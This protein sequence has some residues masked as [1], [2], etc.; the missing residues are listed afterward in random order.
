LEEL[1]ELGLRRALQQMRAFSRAIR[2]CPDDVRAVRTAADLDRLGDRIGLLLALEGCEPFGYEV[3]LADTFFE[4]GVRMASLTWNRRNP[5]ADGAAETGDGGLSSLGRRLVTR[6]AEL[7]V[8]IDLAHASERTFF[9]VL[10]QAPEATVLVS[11]G[12]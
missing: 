12:N 5:F 6:L 8:M 9:D 11:H 3:E 10:E 4:L 2:E 7:G 1:P